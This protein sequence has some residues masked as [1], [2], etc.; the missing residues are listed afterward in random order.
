MKAFQEQQE[1][2]GEQRV[3]SQRLFFKTLNGIH[4]YTL[5]DPKFP[6]FWKIQ[7]YRYVWSRMMSWFKSRI[8]FRI[9]LFNLLSKI[10][11]KQIWKRQVNQACSSMYTQLNVDKAAGDTQKLQEYVIGDNLKKEVFAEIANRSKSSKLYQRKWEVSGLKRKLIS[12]RI[13]E[14][15]A[16][17]EGTFLQVVYKFSSS[18]RIVLTDSKTKKEEAPPFVDIVDYFGFEKKIGTESSPWLM[19]EQLK[20]KKIE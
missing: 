15:P 18:Q 5:P 8:Y 13:I 9:K 1:K 2:I 17:L 12:L 6:P 3:T 19:V 20:M 14:V 16:P 4:D 10:K 11:A 7:F